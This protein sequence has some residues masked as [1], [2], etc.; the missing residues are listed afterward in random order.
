MNMRN[1]AA[2]AIAATVL[3][4]AAVTTMT[5]SAQG[6]PGGPRA[7]RMGPGGP[8]GFGLPGL[9]ALDLS[10]AQKDQIK[11]IT[12]SHRDEVRQVSE[13]VR[14][15]QRA[16]DMATESGTVNEG[17]IRSKSTALASAMADGAI[18]RAKVNAEILNVLTPDQQQKL[19]EFR[20][21]MQERRKAGPRA[22]RG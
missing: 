8:G 11:S 2:I 20:T 9:R 6:G 16:M 7:G 1:L 18:L 17:D 4:G 21:Q 19:Q 15:A 22:P 13:R 14:E 12:E 10:D 3:T 5:L